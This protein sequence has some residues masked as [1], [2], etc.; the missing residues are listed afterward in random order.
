[1]ESGR[2]ILD[3]SVQEVLQNADM[4]ENAGV[5]I[6]RGTTLARRLRSGGLYGGA[7]PWNLSAAEKMMR[8]IS[9]GHTAF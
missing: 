8:E 1:M 9:G 7:L 5:N 4:L 3:G 6:P 2:L